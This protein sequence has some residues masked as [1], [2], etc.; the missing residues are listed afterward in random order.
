MPKKYKSSSKSKALPES[1]QSALS[2]TVNGGDMPFGGPT[3]VTVDRRI[4]DCSQA[5]ELFVRL[6][7]ENQQRALSYSQIRN[8][9][10]G[11]Q[12]FDPAVLRRNG[13]SGR[14][15]CNFNDARAALKR[16]ILPYFKM[17][18]E[19][20]RKMAIT[21]H[22]KAPQAYDWG[23]IMA[24][25]A[26]RFF[27]DWGADY[28]LQ[29]EGFITDMVSF[30][31]AY[32][33]WPDDISPRA[34]WAQTVQILFPKRTKANV[35][36]WELVAL[37][38]E[39]TADQLISKV[40][41]DKGTAL[42]KKSGWNPDMIKKAIALAAPQVVQSRLLD[43]NFWQDLVVANDLV[44]GGVWPPIAVVDVW[45]KQESDQGKICHYI[46]TE[47]S[48][49]GDYLYD[50]PEP[51][52]EFRKLFAPVFYDVGSNGLIH[53]IKGFGVMNYYYATVINRMKCKAADAVGLTM[54]LNFTKDDD[55]PEESPPV[56]NYSFLNIFPKGLNQLN[57]YPQLQPAM[58]LMKVLQQNQNENNYGYSD[59]GTQQNIASTDTKGQA[60][61]IASISSEG[62]SSQ[63]AIFLS[64]FGQNFFTEIIRRLC[65]KRGDPDAKKFRR[66]CLALGLPEEV[67][68]D[69]KIEKTIKCG[70]SPSMASPAVRGRIAQQLMTTVYPL[71]GANRRAIEEFNVANLTGAEGV[72][73]FL[74]P[75]GVDSDP[76]ARR[77]AMMENVDLSTGIP[78][79]VD[80]SDAHAEHADE[81]LKPLEAIVQQ[82]QQGMNPQQNPGQ[83]VNP[84]A[85]LSPD[86]LT[87]L[88]FTIPHIQAHLQYLQSDPTKAPLFK[89]LTA[90]LTNVVNVARGLMSRLARAGKN[91]QQVDPSIM[92]TAIQGPR[93]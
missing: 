73:T 86:H 41:D 40:R 17:V 70:A 91:G 55:A 22:S 53:A 51:V 84:P 88:Q 54:G 47:K 67:L 58:E 81:H 8:Q 71:P 1:V 14:T 20:P 36:D 92:A 83:P 42:S 38:R 26:D 9:I 29:F 43:P 49:V 39:M 23:I 25:A 37:R 33:M 50:S 11:G 76:R 21:V 52:D 68:D 5:R 80:P 62:T 13:E 75:I 77:E 35:D 34:K 82:A 89:Q 32:F 12:P 61:L 45:A 10:E 87:A 31:P 2:S 4:S 74:L 24:E 90:R 28:F 65:L 59:E 30:G 72:S 63:A 60:D 7:R 46:F 44:I 16:A 69:P 57:I 6:Q 85:Q 93:Q 18:N 15:N 78:L 56:Q 66:R 48:D 3:G 19:V 64:Q 79:P 27:D